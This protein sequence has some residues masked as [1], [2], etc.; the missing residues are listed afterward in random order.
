M[1]STHLHSTDSTYQIYIGNSEKD[2][3]DFAKATFAIKK[4]LEEA[5]EKA[6]KP[7]PVK[8]SVSD[9][10]ADD[11]DFSIPAFLKDPVNYSRSKVIKFIQQASQDPVTAFKTYPQ[12]GAVVGGLTATLIGMIGLLLGLLAPKPNT[13]KLQAKAQKASSEVKAK[14]ADI[15]DAAQ[16]KATASD[17]DEVA[18][19][20]KKRTAAGKAKATQ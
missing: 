4:P 5:L 6:S 17:L 11:S 10:D 7:E 15:K 9:Y 12:T 3:A 20:V 16:T 14:A 18:K 2:A 13:Q 8:K 19:D 1:I